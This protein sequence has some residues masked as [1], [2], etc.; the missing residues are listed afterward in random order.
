MYIYI[1]IYI[2]LWRAADTD[3]LNP[4]L[5]L[6]PTVHRFRHQCRAVVDRI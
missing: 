3:F 2:T 5:P 1:Y 4:L 6:V